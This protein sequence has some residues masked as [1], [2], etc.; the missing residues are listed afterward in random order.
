MTKLT[1]IDLRLLIEM[2]TLNAESL[3][4][5]GEFE[6]A[7]GC[8]QLIDKLSVMVEEIRGDD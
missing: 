7:I 1:L 3:Q 5:A 8:K 4:R 2:T 6:A